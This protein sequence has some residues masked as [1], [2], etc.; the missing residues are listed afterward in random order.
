MY[1][2]IDIFPYLTAYK[3]LPAVQDFV[4]L[5][6]SDFTQKQTRHLQLFL[7]AITCGHKLLFNNAN[8]LFKR[9]HFLHSAEQVLMQFFLAMSTAGRLD[10][11]LLPL[12]LLQKRHG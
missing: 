9:S 2:Y 7:Q 3:K 10:F 12:L 1:T 11:D 4:N 6:R 5:K 8:L